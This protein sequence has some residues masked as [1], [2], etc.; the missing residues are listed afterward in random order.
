MCYS[1]IFKLILLFLN[2]VVISLA[3]ILPSFK[4]QQQIR[5]KRGAIGHELRHIQNNL[6]HTFERI[7]RTHRAT[8]YQSRIQV[9]RELCL[10]AGS[11]MF[12]QNHFTGRDNINVRNYATLS[13]YYLGKYAENKNIKPYQ[14]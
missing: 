12:P 8:A 13:A 3:Q 4:L 6:T 10:L 11:L 14:F 2:L 7:L 5:I 1:V 9:V